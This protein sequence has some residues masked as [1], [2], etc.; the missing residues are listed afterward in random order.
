[1]WLQRFRKRCS[2]TGLRITRLAETAFPL[3]VNS[4]FVSAD[5]ELNHIDPR[6]RPF[7]FTFEC[8]GLSF[9]ASTRVRQGKLWLQLAAKVGPVPYTAESADRRR[10]AVA[11]MRSAS[12][13]PHGRVGVSQDRQIE[14]SGEVR[15]SEPLT[16][17]HVV[18]AAAEF[19][20]EIKPY[21]TLIADFIPTV[22]RR[23]RAVS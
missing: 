6:E 14:I 8:L 3:E 16:P 22:D 5:G 7:G 11:I 12:T 9:T 13:L 20:L 17:V 4:L 2:V 23:T 18:S 1:M 15:L 19:V 21:V 10:D